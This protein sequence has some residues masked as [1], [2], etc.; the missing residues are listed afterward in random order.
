MLKLISEIRELIHKPYYR[1]S[2]AE[3]GR[4]GSV[5][6]MVITVFTLVACGLIKL[7]AILTYG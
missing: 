2:I 3:R 1:L 7:S 6:I 4:L 5:M